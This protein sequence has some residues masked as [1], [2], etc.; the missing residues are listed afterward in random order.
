MAIGCSEINTFKPLSPN[1]SLRP[2]LSVLFTLASKSKS[3]VSVT[4]ASLSVNKSVLTL[5][6]EVLCAWNRWRCCMR[7]CKEEL[8]S[9][10]PDKTKDSS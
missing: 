6:M 3:V 8:R 10:L 7:L 1:A 4:S 5:M 9:L 2:S